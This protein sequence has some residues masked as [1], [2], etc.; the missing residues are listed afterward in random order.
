MVVQMVLDQNSNGD[1]IEDM[2]GKVTK[3]IKTYQNKGRVYRAKPSSLVEKGI[4][5]T[6]QQ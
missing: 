5:S 1:N 6:Y 2:M 4:S 3:K